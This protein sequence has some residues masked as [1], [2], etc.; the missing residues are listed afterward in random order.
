MLGKKY[1]VF[2]KEL[3]MKLSKKEKVINFFQLIKNILS[4]ALCDNLKKVDT[5]IFSHPR[6]KLVED[7]L[8]DPY[9]HYL[10]KSLIKNNISFLEFESPHNGKHLREKKLY[11][12]YLD[13]IFILRNIK[14]LFI[15]TNISQKNKTIVEQLSKEINQGTD[16][17]LDIKEILISNTKKFIPT[18]SFYLKLLERTQPKKIY[19]I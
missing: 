18:Y 7:T 17:F 5:L 14:N 13:S 10:V 15:K 9:T 12:R 19:L 16:S 6:S 2:D 8:I 11:K 4:N 1:N 3:S